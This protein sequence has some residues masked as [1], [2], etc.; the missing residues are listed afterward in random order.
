MQQ[1]KTQLRTLNG[2]IAEKAE[3][4]AVDIDQLRDQL[5]ELRTDLNNM[6][7][8]EDNSAK[9]RELREQHEKLQEHLL[10]QSDGLESL[11]GDITQKA[12]N[13]SVGAVVSQLQVLSDI[14]APKMRTVHPKTPRPQS[15]G[16]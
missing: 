10:H 9:V 11:R 15:A 2:A 12:N 8:V 3:T 7:S 5:R 1:V 6:P 13:E 14:L 16:R 4:Q